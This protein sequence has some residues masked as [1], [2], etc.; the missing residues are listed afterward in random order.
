MMTFKIVRFLIIAFSIVVLYPY[1]P[2]SQSEAFKG[3][4]IFVG[5]LFSLGSTSAVA[6]IFAGL[7]LTYIRA[8]RMGDRIKIGE[9]VGDVIEMKLY[10]TRIRTNKNVDIVISNVNPARSTGVALYV[11]GW[12]LAQLWLF[13]V[14]PIAGATLGGLIY[15]FLGKE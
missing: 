12:A 13:W 5:V 3:V 9:T 2:G 6:N 11:G 8:Y 4:S 14:A 1:L 15:R 7:S 10:G